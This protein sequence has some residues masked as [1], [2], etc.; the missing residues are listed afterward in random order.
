M[1][2]KRYVET[3]EYKLIWDV[4]NAYFANSPDKDTILKII[5]RSAN[6]QSMNI[7]LREHSEYGPGD[8]VFT[9]TYFTIP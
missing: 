1:E 3:R 6:F 5:G 7:L 2:R 4:T 9:E 8:I